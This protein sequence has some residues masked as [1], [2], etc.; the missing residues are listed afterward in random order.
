MDRAHA[1]CVTALWEAWNRGEPLARAWP[2]FEAAPAADGPARRGLGQ[3]AWPAAPDL[4]TQLA[5]F[6]DNVLK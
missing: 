4:A 3:H 2:A 1:A 6:V 5:D